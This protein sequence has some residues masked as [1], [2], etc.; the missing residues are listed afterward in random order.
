MGNPYREGPMK[1]TYQLRADEIRRA[2]AYW[3]AEQVNDD[4]LVHY[5]TEELTEMVSLEDPMTTA[6]LVVDREVD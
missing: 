5:T 1:V 6:T 4:T 2:V 3:L